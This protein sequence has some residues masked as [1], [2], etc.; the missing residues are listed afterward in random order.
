[1]FRIDL[2]LFKQIMSDVDSYVLDDWT[3]VSD[4]TILSVKP[5]KG[6]NQHGHHFHSLDFHYEN[7]YKKIDEDNKIRIPVDW[8]KMI[9]NDLL[10]T[11]VSFWNFTT[12]GYNVLRVL[13]IL[14]DGIHR[15]EFEYNKGD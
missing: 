7:L 9:A 13:K 2:K 8:L 4:E 11:S 14:D 3:I 15:L 5:V 6:V 12:K 10:Q 1:M